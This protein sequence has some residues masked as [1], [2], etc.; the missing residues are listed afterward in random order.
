ME[1]KNV[2]E[3]RRSRATSEGSSRRV[4]RKDSI[5]KKDGKS[6]DSGFFDSG[7]VG[8]QGLQGRK[9][10][11]EDRVDLLKRSG[12]GGSR[13]SLRFSAIED[14]NILKSANWESPENKNV[15]GKQSQDKYI[16]EDSD[17]RRSVNLVKLEDVLLQKEAEFSITLNE[18]G[19]SLE[20]LTPSRLKKI[21]GNA[22]CARIDRIE[23]RLEQSEVFTP[24]RSSLKLSSRIIGRSI[25]DMTGS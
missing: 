14:E 6:K 22:R 12:G 19:G 1:T 21:D 2:L 25:P 23:P 16:V 10:S 9:Y 18:N 11:G 7:V 20:N 8:D 17:R 3:K 13:K 24:G 4:S 5:L 15:W